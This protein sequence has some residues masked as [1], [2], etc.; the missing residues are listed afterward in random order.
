[1]C[2]IVSFSQVRVRGLLGRLSSLEFIVRFPIEMRDMGALKGHFLT[3]L[4]PNRRS[5]KQVLPRGRARVDRDS[6]ISGQRQKTK[7]MPPSAKLRNAL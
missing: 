3:E 6:K 5:R 4:T 1:M 7:K 2:G